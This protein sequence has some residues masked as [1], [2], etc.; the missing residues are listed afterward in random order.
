MD[1]DHESDD[2][3]PRRPPSPSKDPYV[4][5]LQSSRHASSAKVCRDFVAC[6]L[7]SVG[8]WELADTAA[9]CTSELATNA[10]LHA[11][12]DSV[13]LRVVIE[14]PRFRVLLY[15]ASAELPAA[16]SLPEGDRLRGRG[17]GLVAALT[18]AWGTAEG[19][20]TGLYAKGV[21]FELAGKE[22]DAG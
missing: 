9:L 14:P 1:S 22:G 5:T 6:V 19:D 17:L 3:P 10:F 11:E 21:W 2:R 12:G 8:Q 7:N 15:D 16:V 18:D 4:Y 13:M 20:A